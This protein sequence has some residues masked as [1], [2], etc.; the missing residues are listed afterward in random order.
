MCIKVEQQLLRKPIHK[1]SSFSFSKS[2]F[3]K[4]NISHDK[5]T[6][7]R[8]PAKGQDKG[9]TS[10][11][12]SEIKCFECLGRGHVASQCPTNCTIVLKGQD[13]YNSQEESPEESSSS[14]DSHSDSPP[15]TNF[16]L[17]L[18]KGLS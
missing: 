7:H 3:Q 11:R 4:K 8:H 9:E 12:G 16:I 18:M 5:E 15:K 6:A 2:D 17:T 13:L 10:K 14:S 1:D